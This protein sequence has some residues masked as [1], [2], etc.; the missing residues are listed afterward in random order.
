MRK[1][2]VLSLLEVLFV[3]ALFVPVSPWIHIYV[4]AASDED[5]WTVGAGHRVESWWPCPDHL[6]ED[7]RLYL[8]VQSTRASTLMTFVDAP[9]WDDGSVAEYRADHPELT[10]LWPERPIR[11]L[12]R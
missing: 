1:W 4:P 10:G 11:W 6:V 9:R 3:A 7:D 2:L 5:R 12:R 8:R